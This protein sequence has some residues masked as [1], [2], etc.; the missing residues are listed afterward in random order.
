M[1]REYA[2]ELRRGGEQ[3]HNPA[4]CEGLQ[5]GHGRSDTASDSEKGAETP[6]EYEK[7][8]EGYAEAVKYFMDHPEVPLNPVVRAFVESI[9]KEIVSKEPSLQQTT[10]N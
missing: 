7:R 8:I 10:L 5:A 6:E 1:A 4:H 9:R 2:E 3:A